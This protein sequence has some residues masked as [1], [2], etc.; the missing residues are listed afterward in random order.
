M[1]YD[2]NQLKKT[3]AFGDE[4]MVPEWVSWIDRGDLTH[5]IPAI[6]E[7]PHMRTSMHPYTTYQTDV[8]TPLGYAIITDNVAVVKALLKYDDINNVCWCDIDD[9]DVEL[10]GLA[11]GVQKQMSWF[12]L[13]VLLNVGAPS[14]DTL[15]FSLF[16]ATEAAANISPEKD[17]YIEYLRKT[18]REKLEETLQYLD[19]LY[20]IKWCATVCNTA[21]TL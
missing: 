11:L 7:N 21:T 19:T 5:L 16:C 6:R 8:A 18:L 10:D 15:R 1:D 20:A 14:P 2:A 3:V 9:D 17:P 12:M 4:T 13:D